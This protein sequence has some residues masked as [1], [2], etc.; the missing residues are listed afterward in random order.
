[1]KSIIKLFIATIALTQAVEQTEVPQPERYA[2]ENDD[3]LMRLLVQKGFATEKE[4]NIDLKCGCDCTCCQKRNSQYWIN[5]E[6]A[7]TAARAYVGKDLHLSGP[8]LEEYLNVH[9]TEKW[10]QFDV[11]NTGEI[12]IEQM[13][14]FLKQVMGDMTISIQ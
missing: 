10:M 11:L 2:S 4:D 1:M 9:F 8:K 7:L 12:E 5:K 14:S 6:G 3:Q 13:S